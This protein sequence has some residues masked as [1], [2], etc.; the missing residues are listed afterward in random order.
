[1]SD[2]TAALTGAPS[3]EPAVPFEQRLFELSPVGALPTAIAIF[4]VLMAT[5]EGCAQLSHYAL[6]E[7]L[8]FSPNEGAWPAFI[9][10]LI[11]SVS[12]GMQRYVRLKDQDDGVALSKLIQCD[13]ITYA[14]D[15]PAAH[16]ALRWAGIGGVLVGLA[17]AF[18]AVPYRMQMEHIAIILWF[19]VTMSLL[20]AL[21]ARGVVMTRI[22]GRRFAELID[23]DL[24][25]DL[26]RIDELSVIGR[27]S[28]RAA[29]IW[30]SV[31]AIICLF[32]VSGH[33]PGLVVATVALSAGIAVWIFFRSL[34]SV[35]K[36]IRAAKRAELERV[37]GEIV[38]VRLQAAHDQTAS[39]RLH[40]L[41]AYEARIASVHE[42]PFDQ[43]T[44]V[45][46]GAYMLIPAIPAIG[47][48]ALKFVT[49]RFIQ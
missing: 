18:A 36:K 27:S 28:A 24:K 25:V 1:M 34:K 40:G 5:F 11:A 45:R 47:Q 15:D 48:F 8:S 41:I 6:A 10:S 37:R 23:H 7:Q 38:A 29:L 35:H 33:V 13:A 32:F 20:G 43:L 26:L 19:A 44:L 2:Q 30:L 14:I 16:S 3:P 17:I 31:A 12:L 49:E 4:V 22:S 21:F 9:L 39:A 46:V 42:W